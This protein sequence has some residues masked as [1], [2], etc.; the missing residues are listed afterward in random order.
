MEA[1]VG[2]HR[3]SGHAYRTPFAAEDEQEAVNIS[4]GPN[5][6]RELDR[7]VFVPFRRLAFERTCSRRVLAMCAATWVAVRGDLSSDAVCHY[8]VEGEI[9]LAS[10]PDLSAESPAG[11]FTLVHYLMGKPTQRVDRLFTGPDEMSSHLIPVA[12]RART[13]EVEEPKRMLRAS[14]PNVNAKLYSHRLSDMLQWFLRAVD[15]CCKLT[16]ADFDGFGAL[17]YMCF[18]TTTYYRNPLDTFVTQELKEDNDVAHVPIVVIWNVLHAKAESKSPVL[19]EV[20]ASL[21]AFFRPSVLMK[22]KSEREHDIIQQCQ[23]MVLFSILGTL[24]PPVDMLSPVDMPVRD[25]LPSWFYGLKTCT[26]EMLVY[27][28]GVQRVWL[29]VKEETSFKRLVVE[30]QCQLPLMLL[31]RGKC[32]FSNCFVSTVE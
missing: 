5:W 28:E 12:A 1:V 22:I 13:F 18:N 16:S 3:K 14:T 9:V 7:A 26:P 25:F 29:D 23:F 31:R 2:F 4:V 24:F 21:Y 15:S 11:L 6:L 17:L 20:V 27:M 30:T 32:C 10:L 19:F 8:L